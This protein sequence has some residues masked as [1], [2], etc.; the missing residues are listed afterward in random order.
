M[1]YAVIRLNTRAR[2]NDCTV[3]DIKA[4]EING[5]CRWGGGMET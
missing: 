2:K 5:L 4:F 1:H 3:D